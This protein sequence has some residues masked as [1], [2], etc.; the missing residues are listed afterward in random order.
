LA[1]GKAH[2][3]ILHAAREAKAD[4]VVMGVRG[5]GAVDLM[6]FGSTTHHVIRESHCPV[7]TIRERQG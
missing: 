7:L 2:Q 4:L 5:R 3:E 1:V 6:L